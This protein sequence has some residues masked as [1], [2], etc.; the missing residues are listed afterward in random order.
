M[1]TMIGD[2]ERRYERD[3]RNANGCGQAFPQDRIW[4]RQRLNAREGAATRATNGNVWITCP[5]GH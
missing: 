1:M 2:G 5:R 4:T 3:G